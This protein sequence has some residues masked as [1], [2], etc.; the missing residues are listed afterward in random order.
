MLCTVDLYIAV[1]CNKYPEVICYFYGSTMLLC[2]RG[3]QFV[4]LPCFYIHIKHLVGNSLRINLETLTCHYSF[5]YML[6][7]Y[8]SYF[9]QQ[10]SNM[11]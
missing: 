7:L 3:A 5:S 1:G 11:A 4:A 9:D 6:L 10:K 8:T 2:A